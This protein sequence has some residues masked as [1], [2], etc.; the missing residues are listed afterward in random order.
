MTAMIIPFVG[1]PEFDADRNLA[2]LINHARNY[3]FFHGPNAV[4]WDL[5]TWNL[6]PFYSKATSTPPGLVMHFSNFETTRRGNRSPDAVDLAEPF[7]SAAKALLVE[8]LRTS[9]DNN[10][11]KFLA[12]LRMI[13]KAFRD[14]S[15]YPDVRYLSPSIL[16]RAQEIIVAN[17]KDSWTYGRLVERL[18][19][20]NV[21][22]AQITKLPITWKT[23]I[24]YKAPVRNDRVNSDGARGRVDKLPH[25]QAIFDLA[26]V[27]H[28]SDYIPD[29]II[30]GW[31][32]LA[33]FAPSRATEIIG[34]PADCETEMDGIYGL[35][36]RPEKRGDPMTKFSVTPDNAEIARLAIERLTAIGEKSRI[37]HRWYEENPGQLY[38][39][40]GFQH[41][42]G[43]PLSLW[44]VAQII[45][46][47]V[48]LNPGGRHDQALVRC[49]NT[50]DRSRMLPEGLGR[51]HHRVVTFESLEQFIIGE[52]PE[53]F[54]YIDPRNGLKGGNALFCLPNEVMRGYAE[55]N[56]YIPR[57]LTY[58][59]I[60]HELGSKPTGHTI[61]S[62]HGLVNPET[63]EPWRLNTHQP[64]HLLNTLA[65]SK[66][67]SQELIAFW[68]GRKSVK[69]NEAYNHV[70]QETFI[71]AFLLL[72]DAAPKRL[73]VVG[74]LA[75]K[76]D[77]RMRKESI[78]RNTALR[79]EVGSTITTRFGLC[80]HDYSLM[81]C[82]KDKDCIRCGENTFIKGNPDH[83]EEARL[84]LSISTK[85]AN[86]A[87]A[88]VDAG[89]YG[90]QRWVDLHSEKAERWQIA[91]DRLSDSTIDEGTL[92]T[93]PP[94]AKPQTKS[95]LALAIR[96]EEAPLASIREVADTDDDD[97][98]SFE[99][100]WAGNEPI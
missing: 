100:F 97:D 83:L 22:P 34:L 11:A 21:A 74:P 95:G 69:Q 51:V 66:H 27:F 43:Q 4:D 15:I 50:N 19:L 80:R 72:D 52:L 46:R 70:P 48:P 26:S 78:S 71:E 10:P 33:M 92:I 41:L 58:S 61:F 42:R 56:Q 88:A 40:P 90:A 18:V 44:E 36:W 82:P 75:D 20:N 67:L 5:N 79:L 12:T 38:L 64:R 31:F 96:D 28:D 84:Q 55:T 86:L 13:E 65:Q 9:G 35:S 32:A 3:K 85:A 53:T 1:R 62:R 68:S 93:L 29:Q 57:Y 14:T 63:G 16:D 94:V 99:D 73:Q 77:E 6:R 59:Q 17:Y 7:L 89:R 24:Q 47:S 30:T 54:P 76:I 39:P 45:G 87:R 98:R 60:K 25:L 8:H 2:A 23:S 37:A 49:G 81:P 91:I